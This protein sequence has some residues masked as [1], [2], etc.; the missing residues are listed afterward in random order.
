MQKE[1]GDLESRLNNYE[2][3]RNADKWTNNYNM[4]FKANHALINQKK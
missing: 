4:Y 3:N 2:S 1:K